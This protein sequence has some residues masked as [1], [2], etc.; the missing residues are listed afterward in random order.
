MRKQGSRPARHEDLPP[1]I[2]AASRA[3]DAAAD[4]LPELL[5][6]PD[7]RMIRLQ[8]AVESALTEALTPSKS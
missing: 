1:V 2:R 8:V 4:A 7:G 3:I 5:T 6:L